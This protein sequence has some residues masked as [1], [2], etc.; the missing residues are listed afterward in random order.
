VK[1]PPSS[2]G[3]RPLVDGGA[4]ELGD[5]LLP[6][7]RPKPPPRRSERVRSMPPTEA[8]VRDRATPPQPD[9]LVPTTKAAAA[10]Q[11][12]GRPRG[13]DADGVPA[14]QDGPQTRNCASRCC[15]SEN[16]A[17]KFTFTAQRPTITSIS[18]CERATLGQTMAPAPTMATAPT[19]PRPPPRGACSQRRAALDFIARELR[20]LEVEEVLRQS[21]EQQVVTLQAELW[22]CKDLV[23]Q[24]DRRIRMLEAELTSER[25]RCGDTTP[26]GVPGGSDS[27][28]TGPNPGGSTRPVSFSLA[29]AAGLLPP[30]APG[31]LAPPAVFAVAASNGRAIRPRELTRQGK[32][33]NPA[34]GS[35]G[36]GE[37]TA[38]ELDI[39]ALIQQ[40]RELPPAAAARAAGGRSARAPMQLPTGLRLNG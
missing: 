7:P 11:T 23:A 20:S 21:L 13:I 33:G 29:A 26:E 15:Q 14:A 40:Q 4:E 19:S 6:R 36:P 8:V 5:R 18:G 27:T 9:V 39:D 16:A 25:A 17:I 37:E 31:N 35:A 3:G 10:P 28:P 24:Q 38:D 1:A 32:P 2:R 34:V 30:P 22:Q 12:L